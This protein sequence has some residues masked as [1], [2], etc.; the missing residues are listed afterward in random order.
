MVWW[1]TDPYLSSISE[2]KVQVHE[3]GEGN[4]C[5]EGE[6]TRQVVMAVV[7]PEVTN[8]SIALPIKTDDQ[9]M[10]WLRLYSPVPV[11]SGKHSQFIKW[12]AKICILYHVEFKF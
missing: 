2:D 5:E 12:K 8:M 3:E 9:V 6:M 1:K 4:G 10:S 7:Q 11:T